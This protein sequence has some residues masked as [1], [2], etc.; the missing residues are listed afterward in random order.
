MSTCL[1][2]FTTTTTPTV[3]IRN[4]LTVGA[5]STVK[6]APVKAHPAAQGRGVAVPTSNLPIGTKVII[7]GDP[8][9]HEGMTGWIRKIS[10][11]GTIV[12]ISDKDAEYDGT[13]DWGVWCSWGV[14]T[15]IAE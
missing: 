14:L 12:W 3:S 11:D 6:G 10:D 13:A 1:A 15:E 9:V 4:V 5:V 7:Q 2:I 8:E